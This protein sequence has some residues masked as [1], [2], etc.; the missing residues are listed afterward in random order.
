MKKHRKQR[1]QHQEQGDPKKTLRLKSWRNLYILTGII[2][3]PPICSDSRSK[4]LNF[5]GKFGAKY[6]FFYLLR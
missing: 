4:T 2:E 1:Q 3:N 6:R 5:Q